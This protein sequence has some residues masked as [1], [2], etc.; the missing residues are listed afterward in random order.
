MELCIAR[1]LDG[2]LWGDVPRE[3]QDHD[4]W[5]KQISVRKYSG[6]FVHTL[7]QLKRHSEF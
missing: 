4:D 5:E 6:A 3:I 1:A 2:D 7:S